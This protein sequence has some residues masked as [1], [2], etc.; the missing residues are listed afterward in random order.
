M[1]P[2]D[3][4]RFL[5]QSLVTELGGKKHK[6]ESR[7]L[8]QDY[9]S[10]GWKSIGGN[11]MRA[12]EAS[13][14]LTFAQAAAN[15]QTFGGEIAQPLNPLDSATMYFVL[16]NTSGLTSTSF[17][18]GLSL[19]SHSDVGLRHSRSCFIS[20]LWQ[21]WARNVLKSETII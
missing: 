14:R 5:V 20:E 21:S 18:I 12:F 8:F 7:F 15:C 2:S 1:H 6:D 4:R 9:C 3:N 13:T 19:F 16:T 11:C 10:G 17:W